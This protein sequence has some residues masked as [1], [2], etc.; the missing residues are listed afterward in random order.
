MADVR[1]K[2][3]SVTHLVKIVAEEV[4]LGMVQKEQIPCIEDLRNAEDGLKALELTTEN[5]LK[6]IEAELSLEETL[7]DIAATDE[8]WSTDKA[9]LTWSNNEDK[10]LEENVELALKWIAK[11]HNRSVGGVRAR[12]KRTIRGW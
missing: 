10:E 12:V 6:R 7:P 2:T 11:Q 8:S 4:V 9:G 3:T 5:R 1:E